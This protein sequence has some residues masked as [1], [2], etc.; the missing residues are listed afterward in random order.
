MTAEGLRQ[1][2]P[3]EQMAE[4]VSRAKPILFLDQV[5]PYLS[6][7][8]PDLTLTPPSTRSKKFHRILHSHELEIP[9]NHT[10]DEINSSIIS[11]SSSLTNLQ[12]D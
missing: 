1:E 11:F 4:I 3:C 2:V 6:S 10:L 5:V 7:Q 8:V 9:E 12:I